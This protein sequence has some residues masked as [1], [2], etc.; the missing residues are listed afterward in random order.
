MYVCMYDY[1]QGLKNSVFSFFAREC[2]EFQPQK[3]SFRTHFEFEYF[4]FFLTHLKLK[5]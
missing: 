2:W 4:S 3:I 1:Q 5:R